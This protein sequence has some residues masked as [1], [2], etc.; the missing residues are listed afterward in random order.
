M[1]PINRLL[2]RGGTSE[3]P[4]TQ[5]STSSE[6]D[7]QESEEDEEDVVEPAYDLT[8][9]NDV[10][11]DETIT[12]DTEDEGDFATIT[13]ETI[14]DSITFDVR[15]SG[16]TSRFGELDVKYM[17]GGGYAINLYH[18]RPDD[19]G[20]FVRR[21]YYYAD[22]GG[23]GGEQHRDSMSEPSNIMWKR[24]SDFGETLEYQNQSTYITVYDW[25]EN[26]LTSGKPTPQDGEVVVRYKDSL[27]AGGGRK[28]VDNVFNAT[29]ASGVVGGSYT[30]RF[31][32]IDT[33]TSS[34]VL[35]SEDKQGDT[36]LIT[37]PLD[38]SSSLANCDMEEVDELESP[39]EVSNVIWTRDPEQTWAIEGMDPIDANVQQNK[40][41]S[42]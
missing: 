42:N 12:V 21:L 24:E 37:S 19:E 25:R 1:N 9:D 11:F 18:S 29:N 26:M 35:H 41:N 13:V 20:Y 2:Q 8:R 15:I 6:P 31:I 23:V 40:I 33:D 28:K 32:S 27:R 17:T 39:F 4:T 22:E 30:V 34:Y 38:K 5:D 16:Y 10:K 7:S 14:G 3:E 36:Y